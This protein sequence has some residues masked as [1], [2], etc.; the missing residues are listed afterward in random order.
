MEG[1]LK[2]LLRKPVRPALTTAL[3]VSE[4]KK[5]K[6]EIY[7]YLVRCPKASSHERTHHVS[8]KGC[9]DLQARLVAPRPKS[10]RPYSDSYR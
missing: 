3:H 2:A 9:L 5:K 1:E 10:L 4:A 8:V 6:K 7:G